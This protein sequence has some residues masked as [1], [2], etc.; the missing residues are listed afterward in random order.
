MCWQ[1]I[2]YYFCGMKT[3]LPLIGILLFLAFLGCNNPHADNGYEDVLYQLECFCTTHPDSA[4][5]ILGTIN[6]D[7]LSQREM[8]HLCYLKVLVKDAKFDFGDETDSLLQIAQHYYLGS[9]DRYHEA[10]VCEAIARVGFKRGRTLDYKLEWNLKALQSIE[11]CQ[12]VDARLLLCQPDGTTE[13]DVID[14]YK[15]KLIWRLGGDYG[16]GHYPDKAMECHR[17]A[18]QYFKNRDY[19]ANSIQAAYTLGID[20]MGQKEYDSC[21]KYLDLGLMEAQQYG[22]QVNLVHYHF[23]L[24]GCYL[25]EME[26]TEEPHQLLQQA[27]SE[28]HKGLSVLGD[29]YPFKD[30]LYACLSSAFSSLG[31]YDSCIY[32]SEKQLDFIQGLYGQIAPNTSHAVIYSRL[33]EAYEAVDNPE[34]ALHYAKLYIDMQ[35]VLSDQ[36]KN[37]EKIKNDY[38]KQLELQKLESEQQLKRYRLYLLIALILLALLT[39]CWLHFRYRKNREI[40]DLKFREEFQKLQSEYEKHTQHNKQVL[41]HRVTDIYRSRSDNALEQILNEFQLQYPEA[42]DKLTAAYPDLNKTE[43]HII[44]LSF[45]DFRAKEEADLLGLSENTVMKY[46]S[47]IKKKVDENMY[48][49]FL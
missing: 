35:E 48:M 7:V 25:K 47:N 6:P 13:Q 19:H 8:A 30:G 26:E 4:Q 27:I 1:L 37:L 10:G 23:L 45:L 43:K 12:H 3:H 44:I 17:Q 15:Y 34:K 32:Y 36:S 18:Y 46:R 42:L 20:F 2:I 33:Y 9:A 5:R 31:Q 49:R 40:E 16:M 11:Q 39:V 14:D 21:L 29:G 38:E 22:N 24:S 28:A 41:I